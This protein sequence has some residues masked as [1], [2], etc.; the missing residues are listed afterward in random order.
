MTA[1][2]HPGTSGV[3]ARRAAL[4]T[5]LADLPKVDLGVRP[6]PLE[7]LPRLT[8]H[9]GGPRLYAKRDDLAGGPLGGNKTRMLEFVLGKAVRDGVDTVVGGS[10]AQS[11]YSRQLA[12][13]CARLGL[14]C[15]LV[16]RRIRPDD[17]D[18]QGS[19]LLD[20]LY[21]AVI[22]FVGDDRE[23]QTRRLSELAGVLERSGRVVYRAPQ[24]SEVDKPLHAA[25]YASAAV[26]ALDQADEAG[27]EPS[28]V[29]VSSLD[30][31]HAGLLLGLRASGSTARLRAIS[32]NERAIFA[33][34]TIEEEVV[35]LVAEAAQLL[36]LEQRVTTADVDVS[37]DYV[38]ERYGALTTDA[39]AAMRLFARLE[40]IVVDP[41]YS[42]K[43]AAALVDD[44]ERGRLGA[45]DVV[46]FWHTGGLPAVFAYAPELVLS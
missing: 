17:D 19:L 44:I 10:A 29:Y 5:A 20:H 2:D 43:A 23:A 15:H 12:A 6:T 38:G 42:A 22:E 18:P 31:T 41:V 39:M 11:N 32:P 13:A 26:E 27:I 21:G 36:G 34:R 8:A 7:F 45:D 33:D 3:A 25:A 1:V 35:R 9:F 46:V 30:T 28:H 24:A 4:R 16:L 40:A 37:S 14:G